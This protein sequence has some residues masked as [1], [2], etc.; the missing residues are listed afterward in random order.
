M[1][2]SSD[3]KAGPESKAVEG[4]EAKAAPADP[5]PAAAPAGT[6]RKKKQL[7]PRGRPPKKPR[8]GQTEAEKKKETSAHRKK[9]RLKDKAAMKELRASHEKLLA[10]GDEAKG[11]NLGGLF[12][13]QQLGKWLKQKERLSLAFN[14]HDCCESPL[15]NVCLFCPEGVFSVLRLLF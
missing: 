11:I 1:D 8:D 14:G 10:G 9:L 2:S 12:S 5:K 7:K 3:Q 4:K 15:V 6:K 13:S